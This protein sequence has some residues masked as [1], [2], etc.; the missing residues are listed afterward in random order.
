M[1]VDEIVVSAVKI[2]KIVRLDGCAD[3][4]PTRKLDRRVINISFYGYVASVEF[5]F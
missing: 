1:F 2:S 4:I 3:T 5:Y